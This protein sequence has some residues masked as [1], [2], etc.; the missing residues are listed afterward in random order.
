LRGQDLNLRP[1]GY[2]APDEG[3]QADPNPTNP[4]E[5]LD[6]EGGSLQPLMQAESSQHK[7]FGQ[8]VV[9][10]HPAIRDDD[11]AAGLLTPA[12]TAAEFHIPEYLLRR[13]CAEGR[14]EHL[15]VVNALWLTPA[16]VAAFANSWRLERGGKDS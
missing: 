12:Q 13:A 4:L 7:D 5:S 14:L 16:T 15:R 9:S 6:S 2:E 1:S 8:P 3:L 10:E 11:E